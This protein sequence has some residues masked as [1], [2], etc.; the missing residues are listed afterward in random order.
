MTLRVRHQAVQLDQA[1]GARRIATFASLKPGTDY[2][3]REATPVEGN[4][5][6]SSPLDSEGN[7]INPQTG[8][9]RHRGLY[10][11]RVTSATT[12]HIRR[13]VAPRA[14]GATRTD[15]TS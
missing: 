1:D 3:A 11:A 12:A 7:P 4:W 6:Q 13:R 9:P 5:V 10:G 15:S 2:S 8:T 14:S